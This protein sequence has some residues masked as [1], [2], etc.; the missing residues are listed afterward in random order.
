MFSSAS[1]SI[2]YCHQEGT[3]YPDLKLRKIFN[4]NVGVIKI[5]DYVF[6]KEYVKKTLQ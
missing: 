3:I 6:C 2:H 5:V 4:L 1:L